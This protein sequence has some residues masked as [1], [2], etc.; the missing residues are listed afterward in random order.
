M[1]YDPPPR[2]V[3]TDSTSCLWGCLLIT[4]ATFALIALLFVFIWYGAVY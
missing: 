3:I 2:E 4:L 1:D